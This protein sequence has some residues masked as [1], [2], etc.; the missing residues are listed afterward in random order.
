MASR[1]KFE[2]IVIAGD[3]N[4]PNIDW[5]NITATTEN[6]I[7]SHFI[8]IINDYFLWQVIDFP[9]R[10]NNILDLIL[11]SIPEKL[12][13]I[14]G[15]Q[16]ILVTDHKLV[17]FCINLRI[18]KT[19]KAE[20]RVYNFKKADWQ[21]LK[22]TLESV[23]WDLCFVDND[24]NESLSNWTDMF[25]SAVDLHIPICKARNVNDH[26]WLDHKLLKL[27]KHKNILRT[28]ASNSDRL[29][30]YIRFSQMHRATKTMIKQ[31]KKLY[32]LKL[33][34]SIRENP[35]RFWS[36]V[37][38]ITNQNR[39]PCFLRKGQRFVSVP[40]D[41]ADLFNGYL[42]SV[43]NLPD[44]NANPSVS[45]TCIN[46]ENLLS[47]IHLTASEVENALNSIDPSKASGPDKIPGRLLNEIAPQIVCTLCRLFNLSLSLG[48]FPDRWKLADVT[49]VFKN[50]DPSLVNNYRPIFLLSLLSKTLE[51]CVHN[52]CLAHISPQLYRM[53]HDFLKGRSTVTQ[54]LAVYQDIIEGLAEGKETDIIY[55]DFSKAF[56][57][58]PHSFLISKLPLFGITGDLL[59]WFKSYLSGRHQRVTLQGL[60]SESLE[61]YS[62]V[63]QGSILGPLL[64]LVYIDDLPGYIKNKSQD[65]PICR[66]LQTVQDHLNI[67]GF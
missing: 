37:K 43:F 9:T 54:L 67:I 49:P 27:L 5:T 15:S 29:E 12:T 66:R 48:M 10:E 44:D 24:V 25:L 50:D 65:C 13:N 39:S 64:F 57:K 62:G 8:K 32:A 16:D 2:N 31:K 17:K 60:Y 47:N 40:K 58:V 36:Y 30:D 46:T 33:K 23:P 7:Y 42:Q 11:T 6:P 28:I 51:R 22:Q 3:F 63:P 26:P 55:L 53:Q 35:K 59:L 18:A 19:L 41:M 34:D 1:A 52:H 21:G 14:N 61:V 20:H 45:P 4:L 38:T 56:D